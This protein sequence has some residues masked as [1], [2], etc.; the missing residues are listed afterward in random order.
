[1]ATKKP[2]TPKEK[3]MS[4]AA[5]VYHERKNKGLC[6]RCGEKA[7][8]GQILCQTH[9]DYMAAAAKNRAKKAEGNVKVGGKSTG[10]KAK[11]APK[12]PAKKAKKQKAYE[13]IGASKRPINE[14]TLLADI[15]E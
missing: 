15:A 12:A 7:L 4:A 11:A 5:M 3:E 6:V 14:E 13:Q 9:K 2:A 1:M 8:K 10:K